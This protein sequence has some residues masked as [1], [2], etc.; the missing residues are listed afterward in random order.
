MVNPAGHSNRHNAYRRLSRLLFPKGYLGK[1]LLLTFVAAHI[2]LLVLIVYTVF[3][4]GLDSGTALRLLGV[5]LVATLAGTS[6][7]LTGLW[8]LL[9][10]VASSSR[11]LEH[12]RRT[13][14]RT[15][16]PIDVQDEGGRLMAHVH[17]TLEGFDTTIGQLA[18]QA[19]RDH[20]TGAYN[21]REGTRRLQQELAAY[22]QH[23]DGVLAVILLDADN[24]KSVNDRWGHSAGDT[25]LQRF[26]E[27]ITHTVDGHGWVARWGGDEFLAVVG[28]AG[29]EPLA[30]R[31]IEELLEELGRTPLLMPDGA[32][33]HMRL[34][35]GVARHV[36]GD[37][38]QALF[39]R[40]D[41]GL[42]D[43][44][45]GQRLPGAGVAA[46]AIPR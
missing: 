46:G 11:A 20:L 28:E 41:S 17:G 37:D 34:S 7:A 2:P 40:A 16:L 44:K 21:R 43:A 38:V 8:I 23:H 10:P 5:A 18:T 6:V 4:S 27:A 30:E 24:L 22:H 14:T 32:E 29:S 31:L 13:G 35:A 42:Y 26:A 15:P 33:V 19:T 1:I 25:M 45:R 3:V 36:P 9:T 39:N 12:Y